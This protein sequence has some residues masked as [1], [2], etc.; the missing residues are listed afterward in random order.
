MATARTRTHALLSGFAKGLGAPALL[1][2][3][4]AAPAIEVPVIQLPAR[5]T[6]A[7]TLQQDGA[8]VMQDFRRTAGLGE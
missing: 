2:M 3:P 1:F 6:I 8:R 7:E 4:R 5:P